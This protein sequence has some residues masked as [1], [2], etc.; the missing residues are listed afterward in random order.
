ML[1]ENKL[2]N[3]SY[4]KGM[5]PTLRGRIGSPEILSLLRQSMA[6]EEAADTKLRKIASV[7]L[8]TAGSGAAE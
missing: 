2:G 3:Y 1:V 5:L 8:K 6:E 7:L 4:L